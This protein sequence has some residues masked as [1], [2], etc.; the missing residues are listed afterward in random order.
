M[1]TFLCFLF[2]FIALTSG[3]GFY[4]VANRAGGVMTWT[5][6]AKNL[7]KYVQNDFNIKTLNE[8]TPSKSDATYSH[9]K[10][11]PSALDTADL[12][13]K[14]PDGSSGAEVAPL[15]LIRTGS[16]GKKKMQVAFA[17]TITRD[18]KFQDGAAVMAYSIDQAFRNDDMDVSMVAFVHPNVTTSRPFLERVGYRYLCYTP[19]TLITDSLTY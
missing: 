2:V 10:V 3:L 1:S 14:E 8:D 13:N 7:A 17:I 11:A 18:G 15:P 5:D 19:H 6:N 16:N 4:T 9:K 12:S